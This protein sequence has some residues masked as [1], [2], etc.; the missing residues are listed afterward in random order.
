MYAWAYEFI[1]KKWELYLIVSINVVTNETL[2]IVYSNWSTNICFLWLCV[3]AAYAYLH[4]YPLIIYPYT[5]LN[6]GAYYGI[7]V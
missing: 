6:N 2:K 3:T 7:R 4:L 1:E 5:N